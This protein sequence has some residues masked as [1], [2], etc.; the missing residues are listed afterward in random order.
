MPKPRSYLRMTVATAAVVLVAWAISMV[1][2]DRVGRRDEARRADAIVVLG[3]AQYVGRPSPVLR[4]RVDHAVSLWK[5]GLAPTLILTGGTGVG[6][7]TS[8]AAVAR[9]YAM[10]KGVPDRAI[11][12]EIK[13]RTTSESMRAVAR[14]M[15]DREQSSVILVSDPFHMLRLSILARR[16]GLEPYTS[17]TRT[18][19]ITSNR[20]EH[21]K[22]MIS[23]SVKVPLAYIFERRSQ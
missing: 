10:S 20:E 17:P 4:A 18:S 12:V 16:F 1:L 14:I 13:G 19:P 21:W 2:V 9:K 5:R 7:T 23:E 3:A 6:D 22:Y 8:E 11:V 15:E